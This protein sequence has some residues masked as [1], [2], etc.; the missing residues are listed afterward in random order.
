MAKTEMAARVEEK[1]HFGWVQ[2]VQAEV[3][4]EGVGAQVGYPQEEM[5]ERSTQAEPVAGSAGGLATSSNK[6]AC[7][8]FYPISANHV[9]ELSRR[10]GL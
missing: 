10:S 4:V 5:E 9:Q 7:N 3:Q 2:M 6:K 1:T 8:K